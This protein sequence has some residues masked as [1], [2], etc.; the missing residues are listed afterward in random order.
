MLIDNLLPLAGAIIA[1]ILQ[2]RPSDISNTVI[3]NKD[4]VGLFVM[5]L[6]FSL[7][8]VLI[9]TIAFYYQD[10]QATVSLPFEFDMTAIHYIFVFGIGGLFF[11]Y[12]I[13][14]FLV[15][16][17]N[18]NAKNATYAV[19]SLISIVLVMHILFLNPLVN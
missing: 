13:F 19:C 8:V 10:L 18:E 1:S 5:S 3:E 14:S 16:I 4:N 9:T 12:F 7:G 15:D 6:F 11:F 2:A 17:K